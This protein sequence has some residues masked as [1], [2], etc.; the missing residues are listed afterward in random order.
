M[1][2]KEKVLDHA[3]RVNPETKCLKADGLDDALVG[4]DS[5]G[6][7]LIYSRELIVAVLC[8]EGDDMTEED[9]IEHMDFNIT[10]AY[11]GEHTPLFV[12]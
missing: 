3:N 4:Y 10:G 11:V 7:K 8:S 6:D 1:P 2:T 5:Y 9:A 12:E